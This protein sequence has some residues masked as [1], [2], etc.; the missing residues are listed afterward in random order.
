MEFKKVITERE[1]VRKFDGRKPSEEQLN[2]ILE[3]GRIAPTAHNNQP[4]RVYVLE[5]E[6][7]LAK[8]DKAHPCRYGASTVLMVCADKDVAL[9]YQGK[10]AFEVDGSIAATH[11]LLAAYNAGVDSVWLGIFTPEDVQKIFGLPEN[12]VPIC[13]IDLGF[14]TADYKGNPMHSRKN[15]MEQM[16]TRM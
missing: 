6:E 2:A 4:Q 14:R 3:A 1:T 11:M 10:N 7:A 9:T 16:V 15:T 8:M 13:F 12:M 5:S